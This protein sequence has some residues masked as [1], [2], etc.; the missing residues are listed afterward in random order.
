[1][2]K[3]VR[4]LKQSLRNHRA[5][6]KFLFLATELRQAMSQSWAAS[7]QRRLERQVVSLRPAGPACG[8]VLFSYRIEGFLLP[9]EHPVLKTHTN[10]WRSLQMAQTFLD[11]GYAVDV[12]D[13]RNDRF[14]PAKDYSVLV[15][16][17][18]NLE[19]LAPLLG[20]HCT[21]I[22]HIDTAHIL[23]HNAGEA[24]RLVA[25][26]Q[27]K[28]VT[29]QPWRWERPNLGI[30]F[31]DC[32]TASVAEGE[33]AISTFRYA[34]KP[35][36]TVPVPVAH[37]FDWPSHKDWQECRRRFLWFG[38]G[39]LVHK[40]LDL[41][42][43]AFAGLPDCHLTVCAPVQQEKSFEQAYWTELYKTPNIHTAGWVESGADQF[44]Q[45][46][47]SCAGL[48]FPSVSESCS[49]STLECMHAA[50][51]PI[52]SRETGVPV[53]GFGFMMANSSVEEIQR[54]VRLV[55]ELPASELEARCRRAWEFAR[56][57]H[58]RERFAAVYRE[59]IGAI[60]AQRAENKRN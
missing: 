12:I 8:N 58:T 36:Y 27:R 30:E 50:L 4:A 57:N 59:I 20:P 34:G 32:A 23:H 49:A 17:R 25:L 54:T 3:N 45:I 10:Y 37:Q 47:H 22:F 16:V 35:I 14:E 28:G 29:L 31:A 13:F 42:L 9:R 38:S 46:A 51:L 43:D 19:R 60:L 39:G 6:W 41:T 48:V 40:G 44:R 24:A 55:S 56:A 26:Q 52:I 1:M 5:R 21:R 53:H 33:F 18:H 2:T 11:L 15:D 7:S